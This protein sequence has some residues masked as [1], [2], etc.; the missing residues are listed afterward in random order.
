MPV[1]SITTSKVKSILL[2]KLRIFSFFGHIFWWP[3]VVQR[4]QKHLRFGAD[5]KKKKKMKKILESCLESAQ[6][7]KVPINS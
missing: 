1:T 7:R 4:Y 5:K 6:K 2:G 3:I